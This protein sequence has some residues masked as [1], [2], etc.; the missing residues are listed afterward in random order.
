M[1]LA[2]TDTN[3]F[4]SCKQLIPT[5]IWPPRVAVAKRAKRFLLVRRLVMTEQRKAEK[6]VRQ[7]TN[8][9]SSGS[10]AATAKRI[11]AAWHR[12]GWRRRSPAVRTTNEREARLRGKHAAVAVA[13]CALPDHVTSSA[14]PPY[15]HPDLTTEPEA[16]RGATAVVHQG[17]IGGCSYV[18]GSRNQPVAQCAACRVRLL[19]PWGIV[20][21]YVPLTVSA[22]N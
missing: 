10:Q 3:A 16:P 19:W 5:S 21:S 7:N 18:L 6:T 14:V 1:F 20:S 12:S 2:Q 13:I 11:C 22:T 9:S 17:H 15:A 8:T 4:L